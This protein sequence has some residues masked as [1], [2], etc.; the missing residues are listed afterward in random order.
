[1]L[2][3][4]LSIYT[5]DSKAQ[6][7]S[8]NLLSISI[9]DDLLWQPL[10]LDFNQV[11]GIYILD[12]GVT[13]EIPESFDIDGVPVEIVQKNQLESIQDLPLIHIHTLNIEK[14]QA[15]LRIYLSKKRNGKEQTSNAEFYFERKN[16][17]WQ[18]TKKQ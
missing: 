3:V 2:T 5:Q 12:H 18:L 6:N 17:E 9:S 10:E 14:N 13:L 4:F 11:A 7:T 8:Q 15:L 16:L 1:M